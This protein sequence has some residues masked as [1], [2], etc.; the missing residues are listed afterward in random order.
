MA[1]QAPDLSSRPLRLR[2]N[3]F[4]TAPPKIMYQA[5]TEK[6]DQWFAAAGTVS[7]TPQ[8]S[9]PYFFETHYQGEKH[10]HYGRFLRLEAARLVEMS[11]VT[12]AGTKG[13]ET[14]VTVEFSSREHGT[15]LKLIHAGFPDV[16]SKNRHELAWPTVLTH[17]DGAF[18][19][20]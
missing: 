17:L 19:A 10:A 2:V 8:I 6:F 4:L 15:Q 12:A 1:A 14:V 18:S 13:F 20:P 3:R 5:W 7:M 11:G 9:S 16:E